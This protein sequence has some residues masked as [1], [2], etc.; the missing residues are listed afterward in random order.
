MPDQTYL[1]PVPATLNKLTSAMGEAH[2]KICKDGE[3]QERF[4]LEEHSWAS[5]P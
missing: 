3:F 5:R 1:I 2:I 4:Y